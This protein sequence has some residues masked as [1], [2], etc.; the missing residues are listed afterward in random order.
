MTKPTENNG[1]AAAAAL[2]SEI[3]RTREVR[4]IIADAVP[5]VLNLWAGDRFTRKHIAKALARNIQKGLARPGDDQKRKE[6]AELFSDP[7]HLDTLTDML[8]GV[9]DTAG[10]IAAKTGE[11]LAELPPDQR[12]KTL[13]AILSAVSSG[14][15]ATVITTWAKV[16]AEVQSESPD[17]LA[18]SLEPGIRKWIEDTDFGELKEFLDAAAGSA[19]PL[20]AMVNDLLWR[21]PAKVVLLV[22]FLP[23]LAN[24]LLE[25]VNESLGRFNRLPPDL[26]ADVVLSCFREMDGEKIGRTI[27]ELAELGRKIH[28]GSALT[29]DGGVT[30]FSRDLHDFLTTVVTAV[31]GKTLFQAKT[32][33]AGG[34]ETLAASLTDTLEANPDLVYESLRSRHAGWNAAIKTRARNAAMLADMPAEEFTNA[35]CQSLSQL[36][37]GEAAEIVNLVFLLINRIRDLNPAVL[38]SVAAQIVNGLDLSE[39]EDA[40]EG[41]TRD[42]GDIIKPLGRAVLPH[43]IQT[44]CQWLM[45]EGDETDESAAAAR[46]A[47]LSFLYPQEVPS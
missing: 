23:S 39:I 5:E 25:A 2:L 4:T 7:R 30:G 45:P 6:L 43:L 40:V 11:T 1:R 26:V 14:R 9:L 15:S 36:D 38:P 27:N 46:D 42:I 8:P 21:Y 13:S 28:T 3:L 35:Y 24:M 19:G 29:G 34:R 17:F 31:G 44:G 41:M 18:R 12:E 37:A 10:Q 22:S 47:I 16:L 20:A 32:A 33:L